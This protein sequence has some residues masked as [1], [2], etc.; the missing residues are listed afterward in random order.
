MLVY[1]GVMST[2]RRALPTLAVLLAAACGSDR[3]GSK[4][5]AAS[6][7][8]RATLSDARYLVW[9]QEP[10]GDGWELLDQAAAEK[11]HPRAVAGWR[12]GD[13][14]VGWVTV[15][16]KA[17][18]VTRNAFGKAAFEALAL[19]GKTRSYGEQV[20][21]CSLTAWRWEAWGHDEADATVTIAHRAS[22]L[23]SAGHF[24]EV[25]ARA[26]GTVRPNLRRCLDAV[27]A[28]FDLLSD[29]S[30]DLSRAP[31]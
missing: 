24:Y 16:P 17:E 12:R 3:A 20:L 25:H 9:L 27:T 7:P 4:A 30:V 11:L 1:L 26:A 22:F 14:C 29:G 21:Y 31:R 28:S 13:K 19:P 8:K 10:P 18:G 6:A 23:D 2:L 15:T 5:D